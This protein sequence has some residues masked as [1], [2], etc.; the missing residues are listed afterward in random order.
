MTGDLNISI[1]IRA[2]PNV[3]GPENNHSRGDSN[4]LAALVS[5]TSRRSSVLGYRLTSDE[6]NCKVSRVHQRS[7][8]SG[9]GSRRRRPLTR[10]SSNRSNEPPS[11]GSIA[12]H[13]LRLKTAAQV[14]YRCDRRIQ[15]T[16]LRHASHLD[17]VI[18]ITIAIPLGRFSVDVA[19]ST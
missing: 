4:R 6:K 5:L 1:C 7:L 17:T 8:R 15:R 9:D 11:A 12:L 3:L 2:A 14:Q 16:T 13:D 18:I 10:P 19:G